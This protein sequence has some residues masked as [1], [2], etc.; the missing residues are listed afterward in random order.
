MVFM[1]KSLSLLLVSLLLL[2]LPMAA[3]AEEEHYLLEIPDLDMD[4]PKQVMAQYMADQYFVYCDEE[5]NF[6]PYEPM[7][8]GE[9]L[10]MLDAILGYPQL[11]WTDEEYESADNGDYLVY[12]DLQWGDDYASDIFWA[13]SWGIIPDDMVDSKNRFHPEV[14]ITYD[15]AVVCLYN[16]LLGMDVY[17]EDIGDISVDDAPDGH[18]V[19]EYARHAYAVLMSFNIIGYDDYLFPGEAIA[20][21]EACW[22]V[23]TMFE[24]VGVSMD[25]FGNDGLWQALGYDVEFY[26][27]YGAPGKPTSEHTDW[28]DTV[29]PSSDE[30]FYDDGD[31]NQGGEN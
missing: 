8:R 11:D 1:K 31:E 25:N 22:I 21:D 12:T 14:G 27:M 16:A 17:M 10:H 5:G 15:Q 13:A 4:N 29:A 18:L 7:S 19:P 20:R 28:R 2:A 26:E 24:A 9:F 3:M 30:E 23:G 6:N